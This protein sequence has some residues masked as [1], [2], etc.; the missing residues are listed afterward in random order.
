MKSECN[1]E[2]G[3]ISADFE[4]GRFAQVSHGDSGI[5][6]AY[7]SPDMLTKIIKT[8]FFTLLFYFGVCQVVFSQEPVYSEEDRLLE[9]INESRKDPL[10]MAE[11]LGLDRDTVLQDLPGLNAVLK[12]GLAPLRFNY[13]LHRAATGHTEDMIARIYYSHNSPDG[14]TYNERIRE[15]GYL[16]ALCGESLGL[17]AFQNFMDTAEA[18]RIIFESIFLAELDP[19]TTK[20]R[21]ILNPSL[22]EAGIAFGSGQFTA[23]GST[24]NAYLATFDFGKPVIDTRAIEMALVSMLNSARN[25][26]GQVLI[27]AGVDLESAAEA[28]GA[29]AWGLT[30]YPLVPLAPVEKL[31]GTATAHNLDMRENLYFD[32]ISPDGS[33]PFERIA[34]SGYAPG[35]AGESLGKTWVLLDIPQTDDVFDVARR[36]YEILLKNDVDPQSNVQ[37]NIFNPFMSEVGIGIETVFRNSDKGDDQSLSYVVVVDFASPLAPRS[38]VMGTVYEDRN[39][40]GNIDENEELPGLKITLSTGNG[41]AGAGMVTETGPT[42]RYQMSL[43]SVPSGFMELYVEKE[44]KVFGPF[45]F[46]FGHPRENVL[47][48]IGIEPKSG[49]TKFKKPLTGTRRYDYYSLHY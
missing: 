12:K 5:E 40:N 33:T 22:T 3:Q 43:S 9:L 25:N 15:N 19:E 27:N 47:K 44:G 30:S 13:S 32:I 18:V 8:L 20:A 39:G 21:N 23:G 48:N 38:F 31:R 35:W 41:A 2:I 45:E 16:A 29:L 7:L 1:A 36:L 4:R 10:G 46:F 24:L 11:S 34:S 49:P 6:V 28:Y 37:R 14:R 17:V 42:G 26:P